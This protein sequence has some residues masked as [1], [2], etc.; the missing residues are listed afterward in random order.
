ML[1]ITARAACRERCAT[2][3][4]KRQM[5]QHRK[6]QSSSPSSGRSS[7]LDHKGCCGQHRWELRRK[8]GSEQRRRVLLF[9]SCGWN[10]RRC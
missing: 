1:R 7:G 2:L 6:S 5:T 3:D 9:G 8:T 4:R 10:D